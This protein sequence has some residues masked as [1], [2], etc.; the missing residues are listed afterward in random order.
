MIPLSFWIYFYSGWGDLAVNLFLTIAIIFIIRKPFIKIINFFVKNRFY[1]A[2]NSIIVNLFW[3]IFIFWF[4]G[5]MNL[6][7]LIG[8]LSF[9]I[10]AISL[11]LSKIINNITSGALLL[12]SGQLEVGDLVE[13]NGIQGIINE[14]N[15]NYT[16]ITK[17]DGVGVVIPNTN[18]YSSSI[19]KFTYKKYKEYNRPKKKDFDKKQQY[20][21]YIKMINKLLSTGIK[22][23]RY[24]KTV[25]LREKINLKELPELLSKVFDRYE[26]VFGARPEY[27]VDTGGGRI[28]FYINSPKS[29]LIIQYLDSFLRDVILELYSQEIY[30]DWENYKERTRGGK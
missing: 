22:T 27:S 2:V 11:N 23:T 4:I 15:L 30:E 28:V 18:V 12:G 9:L 14:V 19:K 17:F 3:S 7:L 16:K 6:P 29:S 8:L 25:E 26:R 5:L 1:R 24:I 21:E 20:R 13:T 10:V